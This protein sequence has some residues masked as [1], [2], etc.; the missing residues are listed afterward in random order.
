MGQGKSNTPVVSATN[1]RK[2]HVAEIKQKEEE[3]AVVH[4]DRHRAVHGVDGNGKE[5][6]DNS[7][8]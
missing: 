5:R 7:T 1:H 4:T 3:Y 6:K 2:S 8:L